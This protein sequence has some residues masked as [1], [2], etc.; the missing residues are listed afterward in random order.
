MRFFKK[1]LTLDEIDQEVINIKKEGYPQVIEERKVMEV[2][3]SYFSDQKE[4]K[5]KFLAR[6]LTRNVSWILKHRNMNMPDLARELQR[7]AGMVSSVYAT[8]SV[9]QEDFYRHDNLLNIAIDFGFALNISPWDLLFHDVEHLFSKNLLS[10][11]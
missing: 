3:L 10:S 8:N 6:N 2:M 1:Q 4:N 11:F 5:I 7:K 9:L